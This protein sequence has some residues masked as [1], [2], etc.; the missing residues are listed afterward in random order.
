ML[1]RRMTGTG[2]TRIVAQRRRRTMIL[3]RNYFCWLGVGLIDRPPKYNSERRYDPPKQ[4]QTIEPTMH[5]CGGGG[6]VIFFLLICISWWCKPQESWRSLLHSALRKT[7]NRGRR[8]NWSYVSVCCWGDTRSPRLLKSSH[9]MTK[10]S[11][12]THKKTTQTTQTTTTNES[13]G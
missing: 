5:F 4:Q 10:H 13:T 6:L 2:T 7:G 8:L 11:S 9:S 1:R 12:Q 3:R